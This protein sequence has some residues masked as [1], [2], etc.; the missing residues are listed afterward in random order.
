MI[1]IDVVDFPSAKSR[2]RYVLTMIDR[3]SRYVM[4]VP[5]KTKHID[6]VATALVQNWFYRFGVPENVLSDRGK[7]FTGALFDALHRIFK[8]KHLTTT[9]YHPQ[10]NGMIERFH[11]Y[12]KE[13]TV[14]KQEDSDGLFEFLAGDEWDKILPLSLIHI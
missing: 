11:R 10:C 1:A 5:L 3:F 4:A 14:I 2:F 9:A 8:F 12:L 13:R 7:E 6:Q